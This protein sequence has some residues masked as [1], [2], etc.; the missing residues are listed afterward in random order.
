[1]VDT[2]PDMHLD[3]SKFIHMPNQVQK[4]EKEIR[5]FFDNFARAE[6]FDP[7]VPD[8]WYNVS[9]PSLQKYPVCISPFAF[10]YYY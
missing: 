1:L 6:G 10:Y 4:S 2:F 3:P 7:L 5:L 8:Y 9:L